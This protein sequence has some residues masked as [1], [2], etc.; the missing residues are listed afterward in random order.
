[1]GNR[2]FGTKFT[3]PESPTVGSTL[4]IGGRDLV[5]T[6]EYYERR[7]FDENQFDG[8]TGLNNLFTDGVLRAKGLSFEGL[9][10]VTIGTTTH[11][12][13]TFESGETTG[14]L[15]IAVTAGPIGVS[16]GLTIDAPGGT[17][18]IDS[19]ETFQV[20]GI[21]L[22]SAGLDFSDGTNQVTAYDGSGITGYQAGTGLTLDAAGGT[23]SF[24][25]ST[26]GSTPGSIG[27]TAYQAGTGLTLDAAGGTFSFDLSTAGITPG[28]I[29]VT[30]YQAGTGITLDA[31]GGTF[32]FD[33]A[34]SG[35]TAYKAGAGLTLDAAGGTFSVDATTAIHTS[36]LSLDANGITFPDGTHQ[37][38]SFRSGLTYVIQGV[39]AGA[40]PGAGGIVFDIDIASESDLLL[41]HKTDGNGNDVSTTL[42]LFADNG[43]SLII[44]TD[45]GSKL[46]ALFVEPDETGEVTFADPITTIVGEFDI[47]EQFAEND[48]VHVSIQ[49]NLST[50][51]QTLGGKTGN[52]TL[53]T[54]GGLTAPPNPVVADLRIGQLARRYVATFTVQ[55]SSGVCA[56]AKTTGMHYVPYDATVVE[57][58]VR[59]GRTGGITVSF[60]AANPS[61]PFSNPTSSARTLATINAATAAHGAETTTIASSAITTDSYIYMNVDGISFPG[62]TGIQGFLTYER[63][64]GSA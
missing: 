19:S 50:A 59:T 2:I 12:S 51:V 18:S 49:P 30:A 64:E 36:G 46:A 47:E 17:V 8:V 43:G 33:L 63:D 24:D 53:S 28:S 57:A 5:W 55:A 4:S 20:R 3:F 54:N 61:T 31:A 52:I 38:T 25:L 62:I 32:S 22:G 45:D 37:N 42:S 60:L 1:M 26:A 6:G 44:H 29:G 58:A 11:V 23:F 16:N 27:V 34:T 13:T 15:S 41:I 14:T 39:T 48:R 7:R 10:I 40:I 21:S 9:N 35:V 56:G